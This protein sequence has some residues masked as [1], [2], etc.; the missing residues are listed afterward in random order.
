M[1]FD[2][3]DREWISEFVVLISVGTLKLRPTP[4][5]ENC[6]KGRRNAQ[7]LAL[8]IVHFF[9]PAPQN[10]EQ[11]PEIIIGPADRPAPTK[12]NTHCTRIK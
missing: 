4:F 7:V 11:K 2:W 6:F 5:Y 12:V 9:P 1:W 3:C 8:F 10:Q